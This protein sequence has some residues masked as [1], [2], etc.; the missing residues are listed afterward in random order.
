MEPARVPEATRAVVA[1]K[2]DAGARAG[3]EDVTDL[4]SYDGRKW[5]ALRSSDADISRLAKVLET[6][7]QKYL[8]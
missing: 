7:G 1:P 8:D 3:P 5:R 4:Y 6:Y 2:A